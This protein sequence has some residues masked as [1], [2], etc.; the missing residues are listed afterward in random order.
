M[1]NNTYL[2]LRGKQ[3]NEFAVTVGLGLPLRGVRTAVNLS[4]QIGLR[5]TTE[6][7]LIRETYV[8]FIIGFS[9]YERWFIKRKYY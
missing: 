4:A 3:L 2:K 5:G 1:F 6:A 9:I 8:R 7:D